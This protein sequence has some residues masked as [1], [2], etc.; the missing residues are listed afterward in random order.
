MANTRPGSR[1]YDSVTAYLIG[2]PFGGQTIK[3]HRTIGKPL[4][5]KMSVCLLQLTTST[6]SKHNTVAISELNDPD[7]HLYLLG[8]PANVACPKYYHS[9]SEQ[10]ERLHFR[11][12]LD[13]VCLLNTE[14]KYEIRERVPEEHVQMLKSYG[15]KM[16]RD[17]TRWKWE[18]TSFGDAPDCLEV[19]KNN[20][21]LTVVQVS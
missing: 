9:K 17:D 16:V 3:F 12:L 6:G 21:N 14:L 4:R 7:S 1:H 19:I 18:L 11:D 15:W 20:T 2:G 13:S 8:G 5:R 10:G